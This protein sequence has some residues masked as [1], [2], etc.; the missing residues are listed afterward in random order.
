[1]NRRGLLIL[2]LVVVVL[3]LLLL[4]L[5]GPQGGAGGSSLNFGSEGWRATRAYLEAEGK[6]VELWDSPPADPSADLPA[7]STTEDP[8]E[9]VEPAAGAVL[10]TVFP[11]GRSAL[12]LETF[13]DHLRDGGVLLVGYS[14]D[15]PGLYEGLLMDLLE[16]DYERTR[17]KPPLAPMAW[18]RHVDA[19]QWLHPATL[20]AT[21]ESRSEPRLGDV[22]PVKIRALDYAPIPPGDAQQLYL[23]D[24]GRALVFSYAL[25]D[26]RVVMLPAEAL[27]NGRLSEAGNGDLLASLAASF[28]ETWAFDERGHGLLPAEAGVQT[29]PPLSFDLL[30]LHLALLYALA[31][32]ALA[33]RFGPAWREPRDRGS[34]AGDFLFAL[35]RLHHQMEHHPTA[36]RLLLE[37]RQ[38]LDPRIEIPP[39]L[40]R[41]AEEVAEGQGLVALAGDLARW[42]HRRPRP[43]KN[44]AG[45]AETPSD[46]TQSPAPRPAA[47]RGKP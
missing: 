23:D 45:S 5:D 10:V 9:L 34:A 32:W 4:T 35:G 16:L 46:D 43:P 15:R 13:Q 2:G 7:D 37:R 18:R 12:P 26:G 3:V 38:A 20:G 8:E 25:L 11:W 41:R 40:H 33:R 21:T 6:T 14:G 30:P 36:A 19:E 24:G 39:T 1:M 31:V 29:L 44:S 42:S 17:P 47:P 28:G 22:Q 27:S